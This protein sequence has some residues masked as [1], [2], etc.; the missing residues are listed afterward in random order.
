MSDRQPLRTRT[1]A[2]VRRLARSA[3]RF[4]RRGRAHFERV[5]QVPYRVTVSGVRGKSTVVRWLNEAL[6]DRGLETYAKVTGNRSF[7]YHGRDE[8]EIERDG[9]TRLYENERELRAYWP[10]EAT[11]VENQGIREYT[12]RLANELFDPHVVVLLNVRRDHQSTL[13]EDLADIARVFARTVPEESV[14]VSGDRNDAINDYLRREFE[15]Q[16]VEF[17]V[18]APPPDSPFAD[19][20]G[21]QSAFVVDET[22]RTLGLDPLDPGR[23]ESLLTDL[24]SDWRWRRL[25]GGGLV[26]DGAMMN[27]IES[28][29]LLRQHLADRLAE[30][31][32]TPFLFTRRDRAGRTAAFV[33]YLDWLA[34]A[35]LIDRVH[36]AG[37]HARMVER[38]VTPDVIRHDLSAPPERVLEA[39]LAHG[40]PVYLMGNTVHP[41]MRDLAAAIDERAIE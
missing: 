35:G 1:A 4:T 38:R 41:F 21:A 17:R 26:C 37:T 29:E 36:V 22:L 33:H 11:V 6:V 40:D 34:D 30:P 19:T 8:Y 14:V 16:G 5:E 2:A 32:V 3:Y 27:D 39:C 12:T 9:V 28:T 10:V 7:S 20:F 15:R 13:G 25:A 18:A 31:T 23:I 24:Q